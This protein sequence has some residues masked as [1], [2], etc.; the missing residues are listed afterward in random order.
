MHYEGIYADHAHAR[1][2]F[3]KYRKKAS[4]VRCWPRWWSDYRLPKLYK[5][6]DYWADEM[7]SLSHR[8]L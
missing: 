8:M 7:H 1:R 6:I 4:R 3:D 5:K 2:Q